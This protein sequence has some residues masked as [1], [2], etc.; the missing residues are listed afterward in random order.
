VVVVGVRVVEVEVRVG[1]VPV[2]TSASAPIHSKVSSP[3]GPVIENL[4]APPP[5]SRED[6]PR[7]E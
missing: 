2:S 3:T 5:R 6:L 7:T 1:R 4:S